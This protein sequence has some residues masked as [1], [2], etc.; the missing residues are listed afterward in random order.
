M[1]TY[2][3]FMGKRDSK[4]G[5]LS[6]NETLYNSTTY[7]CVSIL[8]EVLDFSKKFLFSISPE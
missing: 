1:V 5:P 4:S 6:H 2:E 3:K 8:H 7:A